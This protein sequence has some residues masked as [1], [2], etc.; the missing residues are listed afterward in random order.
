MV[1]F[2]KRMLLASLLFLLAGCGQTAAPALPTKEKAMKVQIEINASVPNKQPT[3]LT[4]QRQDLVH[5]LY[6]TISA[7]PVVTDPNR[8]CTMELG[9]RYTLIF[10]EADEKTLIE[11]EAQRYGC[12]PVIIKGETQQRDTNPEFWKLLDQVLRE[13]APPATVQKLALLHNGQTALID[14]AQQ[15]QALYDAL[16]KLPPVPEG[17]PNQPEKQSAYQITFFTAHGTLS[18]TIDKQYARLEGNEQ[19][20]GGSYYVNDAFMQ[21]VQDISKSAHYAPGR[22]DALTVTVSGPEISMRSFIDTQ[23]EDAPI[24]QQLYTKITRLPQKAAS[25]STEEEKRQK[26][27]TTTSLHFTQWGLPLLSVEIYEGEH[28]QQVLPGPGSEVQ[29]DDEFWNL[30]HKLNR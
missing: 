26:K 27:L 20:R 15:A 22:P 24:M 21:Q 12:R 16:I 4:L 5:K 23:S 11:A 29:P 30:L 25:C 28:C 1:L 9:P 14:S 17:D 2:L 10:T 19:A 13:A 8:P 7:L 6:T 18:G 3:K